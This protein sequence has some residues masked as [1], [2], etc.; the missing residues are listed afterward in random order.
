MLRDSLW[1][2]VILLLIVNTLGA[3]V[4]VFSQKRDIATIWAWLLVL[5]TMPVVGFFIFFLVG[6]RISNKKIFRLRTQEQR[7][8]EQIADNQRQQLQKIEQLLPVPDAASELVNLFLS[9]DEAVLT[10][11]NDIKVYN[12]GQD[13]FAALLE[14]IRQAKHHI[15]LEYFTIYDDHIGNQLIDLLTAKAQEGVEVRVIFDQFGSHGQHRRLYKRLRLAGGIATSFLMRPFQ[16]LTLRFNFRNHR[17]LAIIDGM[18]GYIGGFNVGDQYL[19]QFKKFG[20]WRDTHLRIHGDAVL[21]LQSRFLMDW[22]ATAEPNELLVKTTQYFPVISTLPGRS[23]VQ[24]VSSGPD[25]D[26]KQIKQGFMRMFASAR[27]EITIQ[28]PY[29]IPDAAILETL[30]IAVM[31]GVRVRLM[32]PDRPD[33]PFVYRA[34]QYYAKELIDLGAEVYRYDGGF[35]HSKVVIID[36]EIA[37]VGSANMDIRSFALNFETNA[38]MYDPAFAGQLEALFEQDVSQ[39]TQLTT[40]DYEEQSIWMTILQK[41]S[42]LFSPIL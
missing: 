14:D 33:H 16:L 19:G 23:M 37:T 40:V 12:N 1:I 18:I 7:G 20:H 34:T 13:K 39:S 41:F 2:I 26:M 8:L 30:E 24:I 10:R 17:K 28:T 9:S 5:I 3:I 42:R 35:L 38:F 31:S 27:T 22:N 32:I 21:S 4:T 25:N 15:H 29:F 6:S 36:H 11:G